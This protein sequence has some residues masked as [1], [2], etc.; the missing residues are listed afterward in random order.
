MIPL[1][2]LLA[3][4]C[5]QPQAPAETQQAAAPQQAVSVQAQTV[6]ERRAEEPTLVHVVALKHAVA[7]QLE[8]ILQ[9]TLPNRRGGH[10]RVVADHRL[11]AMILSGAEDQVKQALELIEQ[12]DVPGPDQD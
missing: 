4:A 2:L 11:N 10:L 9:Q 12:L 8:D 1:P 3:G 7:H 5:Q 6:H